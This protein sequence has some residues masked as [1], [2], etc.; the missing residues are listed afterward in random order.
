M[1]IW[2]SF[3]AIIGVAANTASEHRREFMADFTAKMTSHSHDI[4]RVEASTLARAIRSE[5]D[6]N[7]R[8]MRRLNIE[9]QDTL[10]AFV[11]GRPDS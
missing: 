2:R 6:P 10:D 11:K 8:E 5:H 7:R 3:L 1:T 9:R 4:R